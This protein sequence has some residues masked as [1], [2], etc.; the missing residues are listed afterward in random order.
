M[1]TPK[2]KA[3]HLYNLMASNLEEWGWQQIA[4]EQAIFCVEEILILELPK[5]QLKYWQEVSNEIKKIKL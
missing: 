1:K 3:K 5:Q 4:K 2:E